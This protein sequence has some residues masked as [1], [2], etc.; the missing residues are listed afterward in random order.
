MKATRLSGPGSRRV[1]VS[2]EDITAIKLAEEDLKMREAQLR[3]NAHNLEEANT[4]LK[5]LLHRREEDKRELEESVLSNVKELILPYTEKLETTNLGPRQQEYLGV[6]K[7]NLEKII[8][9]FVHELSSRFLRLTPQEIQ[10]ANLVRHGKSTKEIAELLTI[11]TH[12]VDFHRKNIRDKLGLKGK[13]TNL[14][15]FLLT[16]K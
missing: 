9:P 10:V 15:T 16:L 11:S 8:S 4:A 2:H 6:I 7:T 14:R 3:R 13:K 12:A 5:V 1:V